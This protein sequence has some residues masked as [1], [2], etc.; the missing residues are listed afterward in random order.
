MSDQEQ[1]A[2]EI[3]MVKDPVDFLLFA[4]NHPCTAMEDRVKAAQALMPYYH[5]RLAS[6]DDEIDE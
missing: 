3:P 4:M 2:W 5:E 1:K 6:E